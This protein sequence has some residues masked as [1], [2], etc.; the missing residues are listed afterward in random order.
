MI[1]LTYSY[2]N[3]QQ[4]AMDSYQQALSLFREVGD[5]EAV[6]ETLRQIRGVQQAMSQVG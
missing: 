4:K 2:L 5:Q 1:G 3:R 6:Q